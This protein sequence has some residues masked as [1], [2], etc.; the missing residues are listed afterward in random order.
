MSANDSEIVNAVLADWM[1]AASRM[2]VWYHDPLTGKAR[3]TTITD[4]TGIHKRSGE[5]MT[6]MAHVMTAGGLSDE[7]TYF[8]SFQDLVNSFDPGI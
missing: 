5:V 3:E 2:V 4:A 8:K 6:A 1:P 7:V